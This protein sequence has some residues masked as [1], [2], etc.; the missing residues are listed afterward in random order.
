MSK[1]GRIIKYKIQRLVGFRGTKEEIIEELVEIGI[2]K[3]ITL[4]PFEYELEELDYGFNVN[5]GESDGDY[6][7]FEIFMLPTREKDVWL[8]TEINPF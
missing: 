2:I 3:D 4:E 1:Q 5:L 8:I 6:F 7:D